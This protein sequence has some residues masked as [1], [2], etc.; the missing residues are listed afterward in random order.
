MFVG[1]D[2][3]TTVGLV[4]VDVDGKPV[5]IWS[6]KSPKT[7]EII[8]NVISYGYPIIVSIDKKKPSKLA[9]KIAS[10]F[11]TK[12]VVQEKEPTQLEKQKIIRDVL[13][14]EYK[15][16]HE[17]DAAFSAFYAYKKYEEIIRKIKKLVVNKEK[18]GFVL[19][20]I[21]NGEA[22][23]V[24]DA[25][26]LLEEPKYEEEK[27]S[28]KNRKIEIRDNSRT[29]F[30]SLINEI[31]ILRNILK[32]KDEEI[33]L[34]KKELNENRK[35]TNKEIKIR[36]VSEKEKLKKLDIIE[37][38]VSKI[39]KKINNILATG[40][41]PVIYLD[42]IDAKTTNI[43]SKF[44]SLENAIIV[45]ENEVENSWL[46]INEREAE[47]YLGKNEEIVIPIEREKA[48]FIQKEIIKKRVNMWLEE[49]RKR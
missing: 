38:K 22:S 24:K 15:N 37:N 33:K 46:R 13:G 7:S 44:I 41:I 43:L 17:R 27:G 30:H 4:L 19:K 39:V 21:L 10:I 40:K 14:W 16:D 28:I 12:L 3:G 8:E 47:N 6:K 18:V 49:Y 11:R 48:R 31:N 35:Q 2:P 34:L 32:K 45:S 1:L 9:K 23:N 36:M 42:R 25:L 29:I 20:L 5:K 26:K